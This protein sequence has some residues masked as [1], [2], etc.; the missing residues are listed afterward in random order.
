MSGGGGVPLRPELLM[1]HELRRD[2]SRRRN[3][4]GTI[5]LCMVQVRRQARDCRAAAIEAEYRARTLSVPRRRH[6]ERR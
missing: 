2:D 3:P 1:N 6:P 5:E 4:F